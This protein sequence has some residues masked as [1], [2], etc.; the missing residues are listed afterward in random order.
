MQPLVG[1]FTIP[2]GDI[3]FKKQENFKKEMEALDSIIKNLD[4]MFH[5]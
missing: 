4:E 3:L 2:I 1:V 5:D